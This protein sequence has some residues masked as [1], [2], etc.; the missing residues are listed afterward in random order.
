[1]KRI[2]TAIFFFFALVLMWLGVE[3]V[4]AHAIHLASSPA[5]NQILT[6]PPGQ[7]EIE[8]SEPVVPAFS[9]ILLLSQAGQRIATGGIESANETGSTLRVPILD[10]LENGSYLVSWQVLSSVDGHTTSGSFPFGVGVSQLGDLEGSGA[11]TATQPTLFSTGGRWLN[12]VGIALLA[13]IFAFRLWVWNPAV[14]VEDLSDGE[15]AADL[16][17]GAISRAVG[18]IALGLVAIGLLFTFVSQAQKLGLL[19]SSDFDIWLNTR[20]GAMWLARLI[21]GLAL[22]AIFALMSTETPGGLRGWLWWSGLLFTLALAAATA[23]VS[24][25]AA[26]S[27]DTALATAIDWLHLVAAGIWAGGLLQLAVAL[28]L[29]RR[30]ESEPRAW[31]NISLILNFSA[32]AATAVGILISSGAYM[33]WLHIGSWNALFG[34]IYGKTL[35]LKIGLALAAF[36]FA[37]INLLFI[38]PRLSKG[39][40]QPDSP[41]SHKSQS[42]FSRLTR[43]ETL[44]ALLILAAAAYLTDLQRGKEAP[45]QAGNSGVF[46]A[47]LAADDL[48]ISLHIE[49][50]VVGPN[51]FAVTVTNSERQAVTDAENVRLKFTF[52]GQ[53]IGAADTDLL[54]VGEGVYVDEGNSNLSLV[55]PWQ[56][57]ATIRRPG[58][59]DAFA[60][61]RLEAG[62]DGTIASTDSGGSF[63]NNLATTLTRF[64]GLVPGVTMVLFAL[65]WG[66][67]AN[68]AADRPWQ[69]I[70]MLAISLLA[71]W[72]G[73]DQLLAFYEEYTPARFTNNPILPDTVSV[74]Q[75]QTLYEEKCL[76]CH[77]ETGKGD[78]PTAATIYPPPVD[79]SSGHTE[80]HP[81]G[82]L[83]YWIREGI[84]ET[85][86]PAFGDQLNEEET[87]HLVNYIRRLTN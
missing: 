37:G 78:G 3:R 52:L 65:M 24:H 9:R 66:F 26:V 22:F 77:G 42:I 76:A 17:L 21:L 33:A 56:V 86:M 35:M 43:T 74:A 8:F 16:R 6:E 23:L 45:L 84:D 64:G 51:D 50:A 25:S 39:Y 5:P 14:N 81:D 49:P 55:G 70:P 85:P 44:I 83:Y 75:G 36:A 40:D 87:W 69:L 18:F 4:R 30:L 27:R 10:E 53:A 41:A 28:W 11:V 60:P 12:L 59:F 34:A 29:A 80:T 2:K 71:F 73:G 13:G 58:Q 62:L 61:F 67:V 47:E 68:R 19:Q 63:I 72:I 79:F 1:M 20:F 82:D 32:L 48:N 31:L 57:E 54:N 7:I 46:D 38:K 15:I